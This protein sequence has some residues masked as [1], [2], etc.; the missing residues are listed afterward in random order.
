MCATDQSGNRK[1]ESY[2][3]NEDEKEADYRIYSVLSYFFVLVIIGI[4]VWWYTT[5]VYRADL[6]IE[7]MYKLQSNRRINKDFGILLS[8][9]YDIL[10]SLVHP[11]PAGL[12]IDIK[13][14]DIDVN[15]QPFL[16]LLSP[17][18]NF[19]VKSQWLYLTELGYQRKNDDHYVLRERQLPHVISPLET[20]LWSH[21]SPRPTLNLVLYFPHCSKPLY[22][23]NSKNERVESNAFLSPRWGGIYILNPD[24]N[25][26]ENKLFQ[27]DLERVVSTFVTQLQSLFKMNGISK[28][29]IRALK[30]S[31]AEEI[32][33]STRRTLNSLARLL[34][35][36]NSIVIS[37][38]VGEKISIAVEN[39][40]QAEN[41]LKSGDV[42]NGLKHA[43]ISY[44]YS[45]EAFSDPSLLALLYFPQDQKYAVYIPL[46]LPI[47]LPVFMSLKLVKRWYASR[48][49]K[50]Q[51]EE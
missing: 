32:V 50:K 35:E 47:M 19:V 29:D 43:K 11:D 24:K 41:F 40:N 8:L 16:K 15:L 2:I 21:L 45:E 12:D 39:V 3:N 6:P 37:D 5:R 13:G 17:I 18:A 22:I 23:H 34:S 33:A 25:S 10:I 48:K 20:K 28:E 51:K 31:K 46:F 42:D 14:E 49:L 26:C 9:E 44:Y 27:P 1:S 4:P 38:E 36:I 30:I 7:E